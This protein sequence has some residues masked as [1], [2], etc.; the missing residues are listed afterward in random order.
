MVST[1]L[2]Q[3][4][5]RKDTGVVDDVIRSTKIFELIRSWANEHVMHKQ[6][7][8][9]AGRDNSDLDLMIGVP[10]RIPVEH[11]HLLHRVQVVDGTFS[12]EEESLLVQFDV[13]S[14]PPNVSSVARIVHDPLVF[15]R[16]PC[17]CS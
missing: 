8:V 3:A 6:G 9:G 11:E 13:D 14:P 10:S 17:L 16:A 1:H 15:R 4:V 5:A 2:A 7:V 12:V